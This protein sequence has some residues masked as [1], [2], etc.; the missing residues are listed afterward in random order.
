[1]EHDS[2]SQDSALLSITAFSTESFITV[3]AFH[4][5]DVLNL[6]HQDIPEQCFFDT[7]EPECV[8]NI[9]LPR[10]TLALTIP[11]CLCSARRMYCQ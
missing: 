9:P 6:N 11:Q 3:C 10:P 8:K 1:M 5:K 4:N 7:C 2:S